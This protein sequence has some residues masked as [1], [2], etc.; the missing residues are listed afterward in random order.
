EGKPVRRAEAEK[1]AAGDAPLDPEKRLAAMKPEE[2]RTVIERAKL[3]PALVAKLNA[4]RKAR[5]AKPEVVEVQVWVNTLPQCGL[6]K[7][8]ALGFTLEATITPNHLLLG[9]VS[10]DRLD[11]I[12]NLSFVRRVESP[13]FK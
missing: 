3:A 13:K 4:F 6:A 7:M 12:L 1:Q 2:R 9:T 8:K 11:A 10:L 5:G